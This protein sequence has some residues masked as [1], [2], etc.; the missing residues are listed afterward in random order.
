[1]WWKKTFG[2]EFISIYVIWLF[3]VTWKNY[4]PAT[5]D[6]RRWWRYWNNFT[7][8]LR[9]KD[10]NLQNRLTFNLTVQ[11]T[12]D[13]RFSSFSFQNT[14]ASKFA[15]F[16]VIKRRCWRSNRVGTLSARHNTKGCENSGRALT[17]RHREIREGK[18][19]TRHFSLL[20]FSWFYYVWTL[21]VIVTFLFCGFS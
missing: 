11:R 3:T 10:T 9:I 1:M 13:L 2:Q 5:I 18:L 14:R 20:V 8:N 21:H 12:L 6:R 7:V 19:E 4:N 15:T 16:S 17:C